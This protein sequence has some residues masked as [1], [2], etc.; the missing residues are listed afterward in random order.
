[1]YIEIIVNQLI[2]HYISKHES[3]LQYQL[4]SFVPSGEFSNTLK[5]NFMDSQIFTF[6]IY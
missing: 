5:P 6:P 3:I 1:M 2:D 4:T